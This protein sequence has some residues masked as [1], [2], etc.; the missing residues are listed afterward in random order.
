M[1]IAVLNIGWKLAPVVR[2]FIDMFPGTKPWLFA[3]GLVGSAKQKWRHQSGAKLSEK[4]A[5]RREHLIYSSISS[6]NSLRPDSR[7]LHFTKALCQG[8]TS[9][10]P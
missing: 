6:L 1:R 3:A 5:A 9:V 2:Y 4:P 10:V 8:T 7:S